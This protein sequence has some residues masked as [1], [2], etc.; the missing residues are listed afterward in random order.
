MSS[1]AQSKLDADRLRARTDIAFGVVI[2]G[3]I[4]LFI[5]IISIAIYWGRWNGVKD[6]NC[7]TFNPCLSSLILPDQTCINRQFSN[8]TFCSPGDVC[9]NT[10]SMSF[11]MNGV[12]QGPD[13]T[14]SR[15]FCNIISDCPMLPFSARLSPIVPNITCIAQSCVYTIIGG[16]TNDCLSWIDFLNTNPVVAQGCLTYAF[17]D[18]N[19]NVTHGACFIRYK[20][21]LFNFN[22]ALLSEDVM[23]DNNEAISFLK[24]NNI[25]FKDIPLTGKGLVYIYNKFRNLIH[26]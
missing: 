5:T 23:G 18:E 7:N 17:S 3:F 12:C 4:L 26:G 15:G 14:Y 21:A 11:C 1:K 2:F 22:P 24:K 8:G 16:I 10:S 19:F 13:R 20:G 6:P 9:Y 25:L